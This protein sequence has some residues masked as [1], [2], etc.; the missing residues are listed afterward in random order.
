MRLKKTSQTVT[1][2][3]EIR[4]TDYEREL[5][6]E[7]LTGGYFPS[8][9]KRSLLNECLAKRTPNLFFLKYGG[10]EELCVGGT[11]MGPSG[12]PF[13]IKAAP[14]AAVGPDFRRVVIGSEGNLG[15]FKE[16]VL[17]VFPLPEVELW[18][19]FL[20]ESVSKALE[21]FRQML[22]FQIHPLFGRI[23]EEEEALGLLRS[24]NFPEDDR[25]IFAFKLA[26]MKSMVEAEKETLTRLFEEKRA[27]SYWPSKGA[28]N[29]ILD[30]TLINPEGFFAFMNRISSLC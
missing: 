6:A 18:G 28:E 9:G 24:L 30:E 5:N 3:P 16:V 11:V 23:L 29:E 15:H 25:T 21:G 19:I 26:G 4:V 10:I 7:G 1:V 8:Q 22:G 17:R 27:L 20:F 14:R 2:D 13:Q 12:K